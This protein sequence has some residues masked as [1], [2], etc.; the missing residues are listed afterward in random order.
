MVMFSGAVMLAS[1]AQFYGMFKLQLPNW[2]FFGLLAQLPP[3]LLLFACST[4]STLA[5]HPTHWF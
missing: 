3:Q 4:H 2:P 1:L 5:A